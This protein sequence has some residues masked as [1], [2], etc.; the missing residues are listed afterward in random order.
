[1]FASFGK[2]YVKVSKTP[3]VGILVTGDELVLSDRKPKA[4]QIRSANEHALCAQLREIGVESEFLGIAR[5]NQKDLEKKIRKGLRKDILLISGGV[6][7]G[8]RDIVQEVLKKVS[9][10][11]LF[12]KV[13]IKPGKPLIFAKKN[14][15]HIF[16]LPGNTVSGMVSL[17]KFVMP[18]ISKMR[19]QKRELL[20]T[21][22]AILD[23]NIKV[24]PRR[25]KLMRG[26]VSQKKNKLFVRLSAHQVSEN[27]MSIAKANC[28]FKIEEGVASLKKGQ[29]I[30]VE[31][32]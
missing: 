7:V 20:K 31:Y 8:D 15:C 5:D 17:K 19:G 9:A 12:W 21:A 23:H 2:E 25:Q 32:L 4:G 26:I 14:Q 24:E 29:V 16:G 11:I 27:I 28:F 10:K 30:I 1:L 18:C 13:A 22:E 6:S 3:K